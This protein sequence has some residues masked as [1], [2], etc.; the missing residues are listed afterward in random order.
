MQKINRVEE[1]VNQEE[2]RLVKLEQMYLE[3]MAQLV[4]WRLPLRVW[5]T[6][7]EVKIDM[8]NTQCTDT[9]LL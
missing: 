5:R 7:Q 8:V 9:M 3:T 2:E 6:A 1:N 4:A